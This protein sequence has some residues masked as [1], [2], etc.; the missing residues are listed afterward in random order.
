MGWSPCVW[1]QSAQRSG[2]ALDRSKG[3]VTFSANTP[4]VAMLPGAQDQLS[5]FMHVASMIGGDPRRFPPGTELSFRP[6]VR[7]GRDPGF[8]R[9]KPGNTDPARRHHQGT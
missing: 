8:Y 3:K 9:R 6:L 5:I 4:D 1:R 2:S 7:V